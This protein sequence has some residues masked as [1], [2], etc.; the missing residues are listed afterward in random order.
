MATKARVPSTPATLFDLKRY[1][2]AF[3]DCCMWGRLT[4]EPQG[5]LTR[6]GAVPRIT[7]ESLG[8]IF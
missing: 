1:L 7:K 5:I 6:E 4:L 3:G 2:Q 8:R